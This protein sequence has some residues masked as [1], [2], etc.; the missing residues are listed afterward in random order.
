MGYNRP[1]LQMK[2][3]L[4]LALAMFFATVSFAQQQLATLNHND[5][6]SVFYGAD[7]LQ[8]ALDSADHGD[9][10]MLSSGGFNSVEIT[11]AVTIRGNG[12]VRDVLAG[13]E[14]T[15]INGCILHIPDSIATNFE[16][17]G[18]RLSELR[19]WSAINPVFTKC[20]FDNM[21]TYSYYEHCHMDNPMF[22]NCIIRKSF[23]YY[24]F[25]S[26][27][28]NSIIVFSGWHP[29]SLINC[30]AFLPPF[31]LTNT[32]QNLPSVTCSNS[33]LI[34]SDIGQSVT[35][36]A[37]YNSIGICDNC[38]T[39]Y[40]NDSI[41]G[42]L[43]FTGLNSVFKVFDGLEVG[44]SIPVE[45]NFELQDSIAANILGSDGTQ[46]GVY[47]GLVPFDPRVNTMRYVKCNVAPHTTQ[48]G[49]LSVDIEVVSE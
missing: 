8:L 10:I 37:C 46:I 17:E 36:L 9:I 43:N 18:V 39:G 1:Q 31:E 24:I 15:I 11:K 47:G 19:N 38:T 45:T 49:K 13:T 34:H 5:S 6:V 2:K 44:G 28:I 27:C 30:I 40:F 23:S 21:N 26:Q 4:L 3:T 29:K 16:M 41:N 35:P 7:A 25:N 32:E 42:N 48:D 12:M 14:P 22:V 20:M 33:I